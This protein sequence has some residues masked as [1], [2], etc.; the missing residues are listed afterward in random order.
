VAL[1]IYEMHATEPIIK[2][3]VD[4]LDDEYMDFWSFE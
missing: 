1:E 2:R 4:L 3:D